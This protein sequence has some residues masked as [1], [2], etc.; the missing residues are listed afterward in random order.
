MDDL[1]GRA[2]AQT[3]IQFAAKRYTV[4]HEAHGE[5][6]VVWSDNLINVTDAMNVLLDLPSAQIESEAV[7]EWKK[8]FKEY[9][10]SLDIARDDWK[11]IAEYIDDVPTVQPELDIWN[12][13]TLHISVSK[14]QLDKIGRVLVEENGT[15]FCKLFYQDAEPERKTGHWVKS[16]MQRWYDVWLCS[17]CGEKTDSSVMSKPRYK[18]CPMCGAKMEGGEQE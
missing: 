4:A 7:S 16:D 2:E 15:I 6:Q 17:E 9:I 10:D 5:G 18:Y 13:G 11:G 12:D 8:E 3:A 14:G 1:I